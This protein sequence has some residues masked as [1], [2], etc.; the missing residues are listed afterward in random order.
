MRLQKRLIL[1]YVCINNVYREVK[2]NKSITFGDGR[3][4]DAEKDQNFLK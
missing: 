2:E 4:V 3:V 1:M